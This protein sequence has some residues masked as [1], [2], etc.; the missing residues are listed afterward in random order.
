MRGKKLEQERVFTVEC[1]EE[2]CG[3][4][5]MMEIIDMNEVDDLQL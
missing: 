5:G 4:S 3:I 1:M 2:V